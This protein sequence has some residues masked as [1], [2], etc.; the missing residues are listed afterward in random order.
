LE[1]NLTNQ[2]IKQFDFAPNS[3]TES[4]YRDYIGPSH[5]T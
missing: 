3:G 1:T 4:V 5:S 2:Y